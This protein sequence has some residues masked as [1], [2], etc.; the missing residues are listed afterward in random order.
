MLVSLVMV[1]TNKGNLWIIHQS[2]LWW[3]S[4]AIP[5]KHMNWTVQSQDTHWRTRSRLTRL[6]LID[7]AKIQEKVKEFIYIFFLLCTFGPGFQVV[8]TKSRLV[9][10][11]GWV[12][13]LSGVWNGY[14]NSLA[15][16]AMTWAYKHSST[17]MANEVCH[18]TTLRACLWLIFL[19]W[20]HFL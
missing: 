10:S 14:K 20:L 12:E 16:H 6:D 9:K 1:S 13:L 19:Q 4:T 5:S 15:H 8:L 11:L 7:Y 18:T 17:V 3:S 2:R